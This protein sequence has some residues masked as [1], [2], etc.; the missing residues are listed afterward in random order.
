M[1]NLDIGYCP[2]CGRQL[3]SYELTNCVDC[4]E[5]K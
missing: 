3:E 2:Y 5:V 1:D 4:E